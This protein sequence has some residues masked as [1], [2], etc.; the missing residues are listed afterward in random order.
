MSKCGL[1]WVVEGGGGWGG[2]SGASIRRGKC[3][4]GC[5]GVYGTLFWLNGGDWAWVWHYFRWVGVGGK[6]FWVGGGR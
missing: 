2:V 5:M 6:I 3:R 1:F 4:W